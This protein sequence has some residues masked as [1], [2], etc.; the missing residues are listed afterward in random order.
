M[1]HRQI[2][3]DFENLESRR[4]LSKKYSKSYFGIT[5]I[6]KIFIS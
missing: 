4:T 6:T 3:P 2:C 5:D 1:Y